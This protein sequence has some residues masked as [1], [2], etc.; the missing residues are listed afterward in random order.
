MTT[1]TKPS[2]SDL[3]TQAVQAVNSNST[4][5]KLNR[6]R[7]QDHTTDITD[8]MFNAGAKV[9]IYHIPSRTEIAFKAFITEFSDQF[10]QSWNEEQVFGRNDPHQVFQGTKRV[11]NIGWKVLATDLSEAKE[12]MRKIS[13]FAQMQYPTYNASLPGENYTGYL[14]ANSI[15]AS[16]LFKMKFMNWVQD[17]N[18]GNTPNGTARETG[19]VGRMDG[20]NMDPNMDAG[21]FHDV[22]GS[23][24]PRE[25]QVSI[26]YTVVHT[27]GLGWHKQRARKKAF[28]Y[29][30][31][32]SVPSPYGRTPIEQAPPS[33]ASGVTEE[34]KEANLK[35]IQEAGNAGKASAYGLEKYGG[36]RW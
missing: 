22:D 9:Q 18:S 4:R 20:F 33:Q 34:Q 11:I 30:E 21:V 32:L 25:L 1:P 15:Q 35:K 14:N 2:I 27:H 12:N 16:P 5:L 6:N 31:D 29:G 26:I 19:L 36:F 23:I 17:A 8:Q 13:L 7:P 28:P 24:Y 10:Q 3:A